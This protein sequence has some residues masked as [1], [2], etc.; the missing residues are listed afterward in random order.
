PE[1]RI[2]E[3]AET[4]TYHPL[5]LYESLYNLVVT[6]CI[7]KIDRS[8]KIHLKPG[9]LFLIYL[10]AY[11]AGRFFLEFLRLDTAQIGGLNIN[12]TIMGIIAIAAAAALF[13]RERK[14]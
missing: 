6:Y 4:A 8:E 5:F 13:I 7:W 1:H 2:P 10:I 11:P 3:Y 14:A 9:S 12:Q